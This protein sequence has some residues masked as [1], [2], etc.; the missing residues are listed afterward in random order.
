MA[1]GVSGHNLTMTVEDYG[2]GLEFTLDVGATLGV[3]DTVKFVFKEADSEEDLIVKEITGITNN[4]VELVFTE[5]ESAKLPI[6]S[7]VYRLD[8]YQ[9]GSFMDC[10]IEVASLK[11]VKKA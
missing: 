8:W 5:E 6:G 3:N 11:V 1:W 7:Y 2:V 4:K 9:S 10:L